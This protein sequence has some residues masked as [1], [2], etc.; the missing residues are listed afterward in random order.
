M[1][2]KRKSPANF[3][4]EVHTE[5][6]ILKILSTDYV[7][8]TASF[9]LRNRELFEQ[10]EPTP[11]ANYYT[12]DHQHTLLKCELELALKMKNIRYYVFLKENPA[13]I[14]GTVC[15][16]DIQY[17]SYCC[18]EI[19][20]R[21]DKDFHHKGYAKEAI[22]QALSIAFDTLHLH[23]V[24]ARVMPENKASIRLLRSL[25]FIEEGLERECIQIRGN[26]SD[27]IRFAV[28]NP[29]P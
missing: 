15:L 18:C 14:I 23:R 21:F 2:Q 16:H 5:R 3:A 9:Y 26:W 29:N 24:Y 20:Y 1:F 25:H 11:P 19:G 27:H 6:L 10:Y 4:M 28:L 7:R 17:F 13:Q 22:E 12:L 8:E